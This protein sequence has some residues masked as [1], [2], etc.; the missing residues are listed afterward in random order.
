MNKYIS[1]FSISIISMI[2]VVFYPLLAT[3]IPTNQIER[4]AREVTVLIKIPDPLK[5]GAFIKSGSG[6]IVGKK[7]GE[8]NT[9]YVLTAKHIATSSKRYKILTSDGIERDITNAEVIEM[10]NTDLALLK[11]RTTQAYTIPTRGDSDELTTQDTIY[12]YGW[13]V[14]KS[15]PQFTSGK[16]VDNRLLLANEGYGLVYRDA[17]VENGMSGGPIFDEN[18]TLVGIHGIDKGGLGNSPGERLSLYQRGVSINSFLNDLSSLGMTA[19]S[20]TYLKLCNKQQSKKELSFV[21]AKKTQKNGW[22]TRGWFSIKPDSCQTVAIGEEYQ[23][24]VYYYAEDS[25]GDW[26]GNGPK[27]CVNK[28]PFSMKNSDTV[29]CTGTNQRRVP[30]NKLEVSPGTITRNLTG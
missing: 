8:V 17:Q 30:T 15:S 29:P 3:T 11:L 27:F 24:I 14:S 12:I 18:G 22:V 1:R 20:V 4:I 19:R 21:F 28:E 10:N 7:T 2:T 16:F 6:V 13:P 25:D 23:G 5:Q 9:Y 26:G